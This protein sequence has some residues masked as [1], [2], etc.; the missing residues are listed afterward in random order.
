LA[1]SP[2]RPRTSLLAGVCAS[3]AGREGDLLRRAEA[4]P[5]IL[6]TMRETTFLD[7]WLPLLVNVNQ[8]TAFQRGWIEAW[9]C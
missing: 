5:R 7:P 4:F 8:Y 2:R 1:D 6:L 3:A 9:V